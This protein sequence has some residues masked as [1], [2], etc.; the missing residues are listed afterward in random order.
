VLYRLLIAALVLSGTVL[1]QGDRYPWEPPWTSHNPAP[2]PGWYCTPGGY[3]KDGRQTADHPCHCRRISYS[4]D[5]E[6]RG[7]VQEDGNCNVTCKTD[8]C[9]CP[10]ACVTLPGN[11]QAE[12]DRMAHTRP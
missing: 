3:M 9:Q 2:P 5:T 7:D 11:G 4:C 8:H 12:A 10:V 1:A 6:G